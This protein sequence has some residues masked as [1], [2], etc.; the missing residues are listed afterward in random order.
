MHIII[1]KEIPDHDAT[2]IYKL[3]QLIKILNE[4]PD[5]DTAER[6]ATLNTNSI[7]LYMHFHTQVHRHKN[8]IDHIDIHFVHEDARIDPDPLLTIPRFMQT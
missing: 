7:G 1:N 5:I 8:S 6:Q 2:I 4:A 3:N